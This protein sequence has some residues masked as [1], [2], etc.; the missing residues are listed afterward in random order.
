MSIEPTQLKQYQQ[1]T[2]ISLIK[3][4]QKG[5]R[6]SSQQKELSLDRQDSLSV[7]AERPSL[8]DLKPE[9]QDSKSNNIVNHH[10]EAKAHNQPVTR[11]AKEAMEKA[12]A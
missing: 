8:A 7:D 10:S 5:K 3:R 9:L 6:S 2:L 1:L 12:S 11:A 4:D